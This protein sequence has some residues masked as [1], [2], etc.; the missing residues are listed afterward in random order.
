MP[1]DKMRGQIE[2]MAGAGSP[3]EE[4]ALV[5][6]VSVH[7]LRRHYA[8]ELSAGLAKAHAKARQTLYQAGVLEK[9]P[10]L[11]IFYCKTQLGMSEKQFMELTGKDG[12]PLK[13]EA[14]E[15]AT[16]ALTN[17]FGQIAAA[18]ASLH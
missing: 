14:E 11:L 18:K 1:T 15:K 2:G 3:H 16:E 12:G 10:T 4:I 8:A 6:G 9:N 7:T 5:L 13:L 17:I